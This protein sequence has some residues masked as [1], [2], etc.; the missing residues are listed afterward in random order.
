MKLDREIAL[1]GKII[2]LIS[3]LHIEKIQRLLGPVSSKALGVLTL[4][5]LNCEKVKIQRADG[6]VF[7]TCVM[8]G[9]K[10]E[11]KTVGILWLHGGGY[12]LGAP[13]MAVM[14]FPRH[15]INNCNCVIVA[16]DYTLSSK[17]PYPAA[18]EDAYTALLWMK[19]NRERLG[20]DCEKLVAG[21]ESAGGGLTAAL[22]IYARDRGEHCIGLTL[23]LYPM[24]DDRVTETSKDNSAPV[25]NTKSNKAAWRIYL[26]DRVMNNG[27]PSYAA[28][29]RESDL[30]NLPPAITVIGTEE[31][32]YAETLDYFGRLS[33]AGIE[34]AI[35]EY[36]GAFHAFDMLAPYAKISRSANSF[37][38][39]KYLE[40][41]K[42]YIICG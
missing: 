23:P 21:G 42:K 28:P 14:S 35:E 29:A 16:P 3:P 17:K 8:R 27:V 32:F 36:K 7:R 12:S 40:F 41:T 18:I 9:K 38:I 31:P 11:G 20:I 25:W 2:S 37:L 4:K 22:S 1:E 34:T 13:E 30:T 39:E 33:D 5:S 6:S 24:L 10:S 19:E 26:G 15:L